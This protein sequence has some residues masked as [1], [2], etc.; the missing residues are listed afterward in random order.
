MLVMAVTLDGATDARAALTY[1][2][3]GA[4]SRL[5]QALRPHSPC[6]RHPARIGAVGP[7]TSLD[8]LPGEL[9]DLLDVQPLTEGSLALIQPVLAPLHLHFAE[10]GAI[11]AV[12]LELVKR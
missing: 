2:P 10:G 12:V 6:C 3:L 4:I 5:T 1:V 8:A 9:A 11:R 7:P